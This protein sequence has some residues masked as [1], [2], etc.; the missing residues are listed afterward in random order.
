MFKARKGTA[1]AAGDGSGRI[2]SSG[3][4]DEAAMVAHMTGRVVGQKTAAQLEKEA[5]AAAAARLSESGRGR[6]SSAQEARMAARASRVS[7]RG[8]EPGSGQRP[9]GRASPG[10]ASGGAAA[11]REKLGLQKDT[12]RTS[13]V[14]GT[15]HR[16]SGH[17]GTGSRAGSASNVEGGGG[18][19]RGSRL[20]AGSAREMG[21]MGTG[22][23]TSNL[24][25]PP[26]RGGSRLE[27]GIQDT[28]PARAARE[29]RGAPAAGTGLRSG[30]RGVGFAS[31]S[32]AN[33]DADADRLSDLQ[34]V[35]ASGPLGVGATNS[36]DKRS[37][38]K[39]IVGLK[40]GE[41]DD[42]D[43]DKKKRKPVGDRP[44][45]R[46]RTNDGG[47]A[48]TGAGATAT[49][50]V[51]RRV[52]A[53]SK[54][55]A[56]RGEMAAIVKT[57]RSEAFLYLMKK[58][59][60]RRERAVARAKADMDADADARRESRTG[61]RGSRRTS[62]GGSKDKTGALQRPSGRE[63]RPSGRA[64]GFA[65]PPLTGAEAPE[66][67]P[68][69][70]RAAASVI[71]DEEARKQLLISG[72]LSRAA[73]AAMMGA[74]LGIAGYSPLA[75]SKSSKG[76]DAPTDNQRR[77]LAAKSQRI[78]EMLVDAAEETGDPM[79]VGRDGQLAAASAGAAGKSEKYYGPGG[80]RA[81]DAAVS[82]APDNFKPPQ[83]W[84]ADLFRRASHPTVADERG[85][86][87]YISPL[88]RLNDIGVHLGAGVELYFRL[89][90]TFAFVFFGL[91]FLGYLWVYV[92]NYARW[93]TTVP[94]GSNA[95]PTPF[96][97]SRPVLFRTGD[98]ALSSPIKNFQLIGGSLAAVPLHSVYTATRCIAT[99]ALVEGASACPVSCPGGCEDE[100]LPTAGMIATAP[101]EIDI[102]GPASTTYEF[103]QRHFFYGL[104]A[105][106]V[107]TAA[108]LWVMVLCNQSRSKKVLARVDDDTLEVAD[109][110]VYMRGLPKGKM[111]DLD[112]K[113][114]ADWCEKTFVDTR[115]EEPEEGIRS[116]LQNLGS[117]GK[118]P[119]GK[120]R[121]PRWDPEVIE[122]QLAT[123]DHRLI[124]AL[125]NRAAL[126]LSLK[127]ARARVALGHGT[128]RQ[129]RSIK[130]ALLK[131]D[132]NI[133]KLRKVS[134]PLVCGAF[135]T[136][137][138]LRARA[139]CEARLHPEFMYWLTRPER[140]RFRAP[141]G[142]LY[143]VSAVGS[144][145]ATNIIYQN[146]QYGG[147]RRFFRFV[148]TTFIALM[149]LLF[150]FLAVS[151]VRYRTNLLNADITWSPQ[152]LAA[153][154]YADAVPELTASGVDLSRGPGV[155][156]SLTTLADEA[157]ASGNPYD[158][159]VKWRAAASV[160]MAA[161]D[162]YET[163]SRCEDKTLDNKANWTQLQQSPADPCIVLYDGHETTAQ[164]LLRTQLG[165]KDGAKT[166]KRSDLPD[167]WAVAASD[168]TETVLDW[169]TGEPIPGQDCGQSA[170]DCL[171]GPTPGQKRPTV[172]DAW[173]ERVLTADP[174]GIAQQI[175]YVDCPDI[176][177]LDDDA[178]AS[179]V[180]EF[181]WVPGA[182]S[183]GADPATFDYSTVYAGDGNG[184]SQTTDG[185]PSVNQ[186]VELAG[187]V[188]RI[189]GDV[190][191]S[192]VRASL[193]SI[194]MTIPEYA[195]V[196]GIDRGSCADI[197]ARAGDLV[198]RSRWWGVTT[199][200]CDEAADDDQRLPYYDP[201]VPYPGDG[202]VQGDGPQGPGCYTEREAVTYYDNVLLTR[203]Q[204]I[205]TAAKLA[206]ADDAEFSRQGDAWLAVATLAD[207]F[208]EGLSAK[209]GVDMKI[210]LG[211]HCESLWRAFNSDKRV[212]KIYR[213]AIL[214]E[215]GRF[216]TRY[217]STLATLSAG[218]SLVTVAF[219]MMI[220]LLFKF[221]PAYE[222]HHTVTLYVSSR[223]VKQTLTLWINTAF[224]ELIASARFT[225]A[226]EVS[227]G[228]FGAGFYRD[229]T[230]QWFSD[231]GSQILLTV[232]LAAVA[233]V[234]SRVSKIFL[235]I[236]TRW[237]A[238]RTSVIQE[239]L[240]LGFVGPEFDIGRDY[241]YVLMVALSVLM[242]GTGMPLLYLTM[243]LA[244]LLFYYLDRYM[245]TR[246]YRTPPRLSDKTQ[247]VVGALLKLG[248]F[249]FICMSAWMLSV[250]VS[251]PINAATK[252]FFEVD[253]P[254]AKEFLSNVSDTSAYASN[255]GRYDLNRLFAAYTIVLVLMACAMVTYYVV[256]NMALK[257]ILWHGLFKAMV[258]AP[259]YAL[260]HLLSR[261]KVREVK[262]G[263]ANWMEED[264]DFFTAY[265]KGKLVGS[266]TYVM[267]ELPEFR[268][269]FDAE[270]RLDDPMDFE[271][272]DERKAAFE[273]KKAAGIAGLRAK[274][275]S[276][277][278]A[279]PREG[280]VDKDDD[281]EDTDDVEEGR[282]QLAMG[283]LGRTRT[284]KLELTD[285]E[286]DTDDTD[287][288]RGSKTSKTDGM[289]DD[290][291]LDGDLTDIAEK[292]AKMA[293]AKHE[294]EAA[295]RAAASP[296]SS[297]KKKR[298]GF[299]SLVGKGTS[300]DKDVD[301]DDAEA[302]GV[303]DI[304]LS[305]SEGDEGD[306]MGASGP[307][308]G[309]MNPRAKLLSDVA[310]R[311]HG[312]S[313]K[314]WRESRFQA[315]E[316]SL[317][318]TADASDEEGGEGGDQPSGHVNRQPSLA[319]R[320]AGGVL[321]GI[322][323]V[324][325]GIG[326]ALGRMASMGMRRSQAEPEVAA[327]PPVEDATGAD[328]A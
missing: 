325:G 87:E 275:P 192:F 85:R 79:G 204:P 149:A 125:K 278:A 27:T 320:A 313:E 118:E 308:A 9:S 96:A 231:V 32:E 246:I 280:A 104:Q 247:L 90:R 324:A 49:G 326:G 62:D 12:L 182:S 158:E 131:G 177:L 215:C 107:V 88:S 139:E 172:N 137:N 43:A 191:S 15:G 55:S 167:I 175:D 28:N 153:Y 272:E 184:A 68:E 111:I 273:A 50:E 147:V 122:V 113:D 282:R 195:S 92:A 130:R 102:L 217:N 303:A 214:T 256:W 219:N 216:I 212:N 174:D 277:V 73:D 234:G 65:P 210:A 259:I 304:D 295:Q 310:E 173:L 148:V 225:F 287:D 126:L 156:L 57:H 142:E 106:A 115:M 292:A 138:Q 317:P 157:I 228:R 240:N 42:D 150:S 7:D 244:S 166:L 114:V 4:I 19:G 91:F 307:P 213:E 146:L 61:N 145:P 224:L 34:G 263:G 255:S 298:V 46:Y 99:Q 306:A 309:I 187:T 82:R 18:S 198:L 227:E 86:L 294:A 237:I 299:A 206:A 98:L 159:E 193:Q 155:E 105:V 226:K 194:G 101:M 209:D 183:P 127:R 291:D 258:M 26:S 163:G 316:A 24:G 319:A 254:F 95:V 110:T 33:A 72:D 80:Q 201:A 327:P 211:C 1:G 135:V 74:D 103:E 188:A 121:K 76:G 283:G 132:E 67:R 100:V 35:E 229:L 318:S 268:S 10:V 241:S 119:K 25:A 252:D 5:A 89:L 261:K 168:P 257:P 300:H 71:S 59:K 128:R 190:R 178:D 249:V 54:S 238:M 284:I 207:G 205:R 141:D 239:D 203:G 41:R 297:P 53:Q 93:Y 171:F 31:E 189:D 48:A 143:R 165:A 276:L 311:P 185:A 169:R 144:E 296:P 181:T 123:D 208:G 321:G 199:S 236:F 279:I 289:D 124:T 265:A 56:A 253:I 197:M 23:R 222:K 37:A 196:D 232:S 136:F 64:V 117:F 17:G 84:I 220:E 40:P 170:T 22:M 20:A 230:P 140:Y 305:V 30:R 6:V 221:L 162:T 315:D 286:D 233:P 109:Y 58:V 200:S 323:G 235:G 301:E 81:A 2:S 180:C 179:T 202:V 44:E 160:L 120:N 314:D 29:R 186:V 302:S 161:A 63:A 245:V 288:D 38:A 134:R 116:R 51:A 164:A 129:V 70:K 328:A 151:E 322:G 218:T 97:L 266:T 176:T 312:M 133:Q 14:G 269:I 112:A 290:D 11:R 281:N 243:T 75:R 39:S 223:I 108:I 52:F 45:D 77:L 154:V 16:M 83:V 47:G 270:A 250:Y 293:A 260:S 69:K 66:T 264:V 251:V 94:E 271:V 285:D 248:V 242:Y 13:N 262:V 21:V 8:E 36:R 78:K 60:R 152:A 274:L 267:T 3:H